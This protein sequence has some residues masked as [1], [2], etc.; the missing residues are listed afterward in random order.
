MKS[1][2]DAI[3]NLIDISTEE[4]KEVSKSSNRMNS[5]GDNL[6]EFIKDLFAGTFNDD[7]EKRNEKIS[8][9]FSYL[10]NSSNPPDIMLK[11][12]DAIEV[13]KI[14][15][16][17]N[18]DITTELQLNSSY[19]KEKLYSNSTMISRSC[20]EAEDWTEKDMIYV[21]GAIDKE[22]KRNN[23][24]SLFFVYG[25]EY[26]AE[27]NTYVKIKNLIS[28]TLKSTP[29]LELAKTNEIARVNKVDPLGIT[30][31]RVRGM[32]LIKNPWVVF[33]YI[34]E[35]NKKKNFNFCA[36]IN[37]E[38]YNSFNNKNLLEEISRKDNRLKIED[39]NIKNPNNPAKLIKVKLITFFK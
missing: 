14:E 3:I 31:L 32:W 38:K 9:V 20:K 34:Y 33:D 23:L 10:G 39:K 2:I 30:S 19:P 16:S 27:E 28:N 7:K 37:E 1:I 24:H 25:S 17:K 4:I 13:K 29:G 15:A 8:E 26:A 5:M 21:I 22:E 6:E 11:N 36:I 12:G 18:K 35:R